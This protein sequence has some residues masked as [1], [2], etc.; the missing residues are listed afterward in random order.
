MRFDSISIDTRSLAPG[1][2]YIAISGENFDG[3]DFVEQAAAAGAV[4]AVVSRDLDCELPQ[5][6]VTNTR[7]AL[8]VVAAF[9]RDQYH[10]KVVAVTGSAG[11]TTVKEMTASILRQR[12]KVLAT[13]GNFQ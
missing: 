3:N 5:L 2:L 8:G 12:G 10:G 1:D 6:P 9:N 13:R 4:G 11:K 7:H